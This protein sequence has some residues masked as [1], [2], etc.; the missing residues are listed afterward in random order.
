M[1]QKKEQFKASFFIYYLLIKNLNN[2][3]YGTIILGKTHN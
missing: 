1:I 3:D 2:L